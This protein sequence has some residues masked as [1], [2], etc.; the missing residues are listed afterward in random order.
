MDTNVFTVACGALASINL[1]LPP[2]CFP[3]P[4]CCPTKPST[5]LHFNAGTSQ[6]LQPA[7]TTTAGNACE[8]PVQWVRTLR[9]T[10]LAEFLT[11]MSWRSSFR[12]ANFKS[13]NKKLA[14]NTQDLCC[15]PRCSLY[16][17]PCTYRL[18]LLSR[19][20]EFSLSK[21]IWFYFKSIDM[22]HASWYIILSWTIKYLC[23]L[24]IFYKEVCID[25]HVLWKKETAVKFV[26]AEW[27]VKSEEWRV[28]KEKW[29]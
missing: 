6:R 29:K 16:S 21:S 13:L 4:A 23:A 24:Y 17:C 27:R 9:H 3:Y 18:P 22:R 14:L 28:C 12:A 5:S 26:T 8:H 20:P 1:K 15:A 19:G 7:F 2:G 10:T 25:G 11:T